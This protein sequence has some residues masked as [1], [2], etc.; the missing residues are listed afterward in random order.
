MIRRGHIRHGRILARRTVEVLLSEGGAG[1]VAR[2][3]RHWAH[4]N[5]PWS[6]SRA[7]RVRSNTIEQ[8][9][10]LWRLL[11]EP[12]AAELAE[13]RRRAAEFEIRPLISV[14]V[15]VFDPPLSVLQEMAESVLGQTYGNLELCVANAGAD[16]A[17]ARLLD[18]LGASDSRVKVR[19]LPDNRGVSANSNA[20]LELA[21][22]DFI[23]LVDHDDV[24]APQA[25]YAIVDAINEDPT[26]DVLYSDD[27]RLT[28]W[29]TRVP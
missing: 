21:S 20:A 19:H 7:V 22:G 18:Q 8:R 4:L 26:A 27:D 2:R 3:A 25:L 13:Q 11:N 23:A 10:H 9:Y 12:R 5:V 17:C 16:P 6:D 14:V 15:P 29:R 1:E 28:M 24:L